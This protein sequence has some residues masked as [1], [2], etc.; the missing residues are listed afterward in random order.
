[1]LK[2]CKKNVVY[3]K[4]TGSELFEEAYF[5]V[6]EKRASGKRE[7]DILDEANKIILNSPIRNYFLGD[8]PKKK[9]KKHFSTL[10][11]ILGA[12]VM[13]AL[14]TLIYLLL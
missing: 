7:S 2:G 3:I 6:S 1:M 11:F 9:T 12:S 14:N 10:S 4:N 13:A 5:I 8:E